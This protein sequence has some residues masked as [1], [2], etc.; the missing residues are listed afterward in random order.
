MKL[1]AF[2]G[3]LMVCLCS[4]V[5]TQAAVVYTTLLEF[6]FDTAN[7]HNSNT[8]SYG[9]ASVSGISGNF[10]TTHAS[11]SAGIEGYGAGGSTGGAYNRYS[12]TSTSATTGVPIAYFTLTAPMG[13]DAVNFDT[14]SN[15]NYSYTQPSYNV[16]VDFGTKSGG[17]YSWANAG[18]FLATSGGW[19]SKS[20]SFSSLAG[21][22]GAGDYAIRFVAQ[23]SST[24]SDFLGLDNVKL[25]SNVPEPSALSLFATGLGGLAMIRYRRS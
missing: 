2:F 11:G 20:I 17:S 23:T 18:T 10:V 7:N 16:N 1:N 21:N 4:L 6:N 15:H 25:V 3:I 19:I 12:G 22:L 5:R 13:F 9:V 24:Q 8:E 14:W